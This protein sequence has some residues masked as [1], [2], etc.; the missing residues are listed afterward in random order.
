[1]GNIGRETGKRIEIKTLFR[2]GNHKYIAIDE[3]LLVL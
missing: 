2:L 3:P 1:M